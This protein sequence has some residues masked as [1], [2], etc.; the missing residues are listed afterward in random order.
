MVRTRPSTG[1]PLAGIAPAFPRK[2]KRALPPAAAVVAV[3]AMATMAAAGAGRSAGL[4]SA[5]TGMGFVTRAGAAL[6]LDGRPFRFAGPNIYWL[7]L[8]GDGYPTRFRVD[9]AL[10]TARAMGATVVR[11]HTMGI[12]VGCSLCVEPSRGHFNATA[13]AHID[14]A[15]KAARD[16]GLRLIIPLV[17]NWRYYHG[18][19]HTFTDWRGIADEDQFY[20]NKTVIGDFEQ[21][22]GHLLTHV[23]TYTDVAY[24]DDPTI[25]AWETGNELRA[26][27]R[28]VRTIAGYIKGVDHHHLVLD[29]DYGVGLDGPPP[30]SVD[31]LS[32][33]YYPAD[34]T[35]LKDA[36]AA[37]RAAGRPF[38]A[39][40]FD[41][42]GKSGGD[43][44]DAFLAAAQSTRAVSG[45]LY[46][47]L[48]GHDDTFGYVDHSPSYTL[49]YPGD[50]PAMRRA[51]QALRRHAYAMSGLTAPAYPYP[52]DP[53]DHQRHNRPYRLAWDGR[54]GH[55]Y[56]RARDTRVQ[57]P[58]DCRVRPLRDRQ[59][60]AVDRR[61]AA[62][63]RG[64]VPRPRLQSLR[65]ARPLLPRLYG[66]G[67]R[68]PG[69][70]RRLE[71]LEQDV[72]P[73]AQP[74]LRHRC[75]SIHR[76]RCVRRGA[77]QDDAR[78]D[79][80]EEAGPDRVRGRS[81]FLAGRSRVAFRPVH[82]DQWDGVDARDSNDHRRKRGLERVLLH[83]ERPDA[84]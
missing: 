7:G 57:R 60:D 11:A 76:R 16:H 13:L 42:Q 20:T 81:I 30:S 36:A 25:M 45:D 37:A 35:K 83:L 78:R 67:E 53:A 52:W 47:A 64:V 70:G 40:E 9:D 33:H 72:Q 22:I 21:Y 5:A 6:L 51:A 62:G 82:V 61:V 41:W 32:D 59:L 63:G 69:R 18:G 10:T 65:R 26:P 48:F 4:P 12:S 14:Y 49:H 56:G 71:R 29:G 44:L 80:V 24:K 58:L 31:I 55:L 43:P 54:G 73:Y 39:G 75:R 23:N 17:D 19:K 3:V 79:R 68:E 2:I 28:W 27:A 84:R 34:V 38:I 1:E 74:A 66:A 50:T 15:V 46:W 77:D 8:Q